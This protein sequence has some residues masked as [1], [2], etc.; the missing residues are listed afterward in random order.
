MAVRTPIP[1]QRELTKTETLNTFESWRQTL[2]YI[3]SLDPRFE[4]FTQP[5]VTWLKQSQANPTRGFA[6][7]GENVPEAQR[8]T[9][10][11]KKIN[12]E[13]FLGF[14]ANYAPIIS[15][16]AIVK[17]S[18][19]L[20][21][22]WQSLRQHYHFQRT[23]SHF[24]DLADITFDTR[25]NELPEDLY[26][27]LLSFYDDNL[28][29]A[30]GNIT[31]HGVVPT[32]EEMSP[33]LENMLVFQWLYLINQHL[34]K[35][36]KQRYGTELRNKTLASIKPE[37]SETLD[38]LLSEIQSTEDA[39]VLRSVTRQGGRQSSR[40][41]HQQYPTNTSN[42]TRSSTNK[43]CPLCKE[44][45]R[46]SSHF[47]SSCHYLPQSDKL[48][49]AK[50]RHII[51][52][53]SDLVEEASYDFDQ[54][55]VDDDEQEPSTLTPTYA[56]RVNVKK[57]P[58][59]RVFYGRHPLV[60]TID[61]G[62]ETT[63]MKAS[64]A[65]F[66]RVT[67][68]RSDQ[69]AFQ[70][71]GVTPLTVIGETRFSVTRDN[72]K[73][74]VEALV[75]EELENE[76]LAGTTFMCSND[77]AIRPAKNEIKIKDTYTI[78]YGRGDT[79]SNPCKIRRAHVLRAPPRG[80]LLWP[81]D[82]IDITVPKELTDLDV[83]L[84]PRY[85]SKANKHSN[86]LKPDILPTV[87]CHIRIV[88]TSSMPQKLTKNEHFGQVLPVMPPCDKAYDIPCAVNLVSKSDTDTIKLD[89]DSTMPLEFRTKFQSV[90]AEFQ[91]VFANDIPGYNGAKGPLKAV[92][93]MGPTLPPQRKG[94]VPMYSHNKLT[95]LQAKFS[96]LEALGVFQRPEEAGV[97]A[98]YVNPSFLI[99]KPSGGHRLVTAFADVG[100]YCKPQPSLMSDI[101][102]T[103]RTI[104]GWK[105]IITSDLSKAFYQIPLAKESIKY[106][107]VVTPF[108]GVRVYTRCA[109]GMPGSETALEELMYLV[110]GDLIEEGVVTKLADDLYCGGDSYEH[111]L[112]N[113]RRVLE[114]LKMCD[115]RLS[116]N[117]TVITP[118]STTI[119]GWIW[120]EGSLS[121]SPHRVS[122]LSTCEQPTTVRNM[123]SF[124]GAYKTLSRVLPRCAQL[125]SPLEEG[126]MGLKSQDHVTWTESLQD[127][128][129]T[130]QSYLSSRQAIVLPKRDDQ[131]WIVTDGSVKECGIGATLYV[132]RGGS[133][134]VAGFYS[135]KLRKHQVTWL[136]CEVEALGIASAIK[137]YSPYIIQSTRSACV[138][139]DSKPCVQAIQK[140]YRGEFSASPRVTSFL[141]TASRF[142]VSICHLAGAANI[143]SDFASRNAPTC[144]E[145]HCQICSFIHET[146][147]SVV[148]KTC[149]ADIIGGQARLPFTS[150]AAWRSTQMDDQD[151][152][153]V[154]AHLSQGT[155]PSKK[156]TNL[157]DIKRY[158]NIATIARDGLLIV[159]RHGQI[160]TACECILVPR[161][162]LNGLL[163]ALHIKLDHPTIHQMKKVVNRHFYALDLNKGIENVCSSC[164]QCAALRP[165]PSCLI[166]QSTGD[167]PDCVGVS[168]AADVLKRQKQNIL[169]VR[170]TIT[171]Y[172][173]SQIVENEQR[174]T[175]RSALA[176]LCMAIKPIDGPPAVIRVDPAAGFAAL[177]NDK[178]L[179]D[180]GIQ[181]EVG[182][183]KNVNKNPVAEKAIGELEGEIL[184]QDPSGNPL[185]V[186]TLALATARLNSRIRGRGLSARE[187]LL[188]RNQF[189]N[190]QIPISDYDL[191]C[192]QHVQ[193][194][195]NHPHSEKSKAAGHHPALTPCLKVGN[196]VYLYRDR[197]K[198]KARDRYIVVSIDGNWCFIRKFSGSQLRS[199]SYKVKL[200]ECYLVPCHTF[201]RVQKVDN[202]E[203]MFVCE[204]A[205]ISHD[206]ADQPAQ[207]TPINHAP[208][209][210]PDLPSVLTE[211]LQTPITQSDSHTAHNS[212]PMSINQSDMSPESHVN[213]PYETDS[214]HEDSN[215]DTY[216][217][218]RPQRQCR[219]P[220]YLQDY[221]LST[222]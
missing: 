29:K 93:N 153:R 117:K 121:A 200:S 83:S 54:V 118:K 48:Y 209:E 173:L 160:A 81:G 182:R 91:D 89:P 95:E 98:E 109:M 186:V 188:Q 134:L 105:Y 17:N 129:K 217:N 58:E 108:H 46:N 149:V 67:I 21:A 157:T 13:L 103:L 65:R 141:T 49:M 60:L 183:I 88:N 22:I 10:Q 174:D 73:L 101:D 87:G 92:I 181:I 162:V 218:S 59:F 152:R 9:A 110:L 27:R 158:I 150:R 207:V 137:H 165:I 136:P 206:V 135:A 143:P 44:A 222:P 107:G 166:E 187:M 220:A 78:T 76:I 71:D 31:H 97:V 126:I 171:S 189:T 179:S 204:D 212:S 64:L 111:L 25:N 61:S 12:L 131:L 45:K 170:E 201:E 70:A 56:R 215:T 127:A 104:A 16:A 219:L 198:N 180:I 63:M 128:Y 138:L 213:E 184:K 2:I 214:D 169:V 132:S 221:D 139:T 24:L 199:S 68:S 11:Q 195:S 119:L 148:Q 69:R 205:T 99:N 176:C 1:K 19:S 210:P 51:G 163:T 203:D 75:V 3:A 208:P 113:W 151:L 94:R 130:A 161:A 42:I 142:Q 47:L 175:L 168:F 120:S 55:T 100:R 5:G 4:P 197:D 40:F 115:L 50:A 192:S 202:H 37:I 147:E 15:R 43:S 35:L 211:P 164:H 191:I 20:V 28:L 96:E 7:D 167:P 133:P 185:T 125:I 177:S 57:S 36:V 32:D 30:D 216:V 145:P 114:T 39:K 84:E 124:I 196:I 112:Q 26:Q 82:F 159:R 14:I 178:T 123:R 8:L 79:N 85:D 6:A 154:H 86:W 90:L 146:E 155:R 194:T 190:E 41:Q 140:L 156:L 193:R 18:T 116:A 72:I 62:A 33:S 53:E 144:E 23:G 34:P 106:C 66:L 77:I 38:T 74:Y 122:T 102:G 172:T 52:S 80:A